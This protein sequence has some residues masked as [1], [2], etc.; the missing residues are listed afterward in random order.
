MGCDDLRRPEDAGGE[1]DVELLV[2]RASGQRECAG[3]TAVDRDVPTLTV[4][5]DL[6]RREVLCREV[7]DDVRREIGNACHRR[8]IGPVG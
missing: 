4:E 8:Q 3:G 2:L 6:I 7:A 1:V 5:C